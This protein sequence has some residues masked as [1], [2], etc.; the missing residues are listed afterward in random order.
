M[1]VI[2]SW[3]SEKAN[4]VRETSKF[5]NW[6]EP[7]AGAEFPAEANRYHLYVSLA[8][9]WANRT[10]ITLYMKGLQDIIGLSVTHPLFQRTRPEDPEDDHVGWAFV[11]PTETPWL[12]GPSG[13]GQ[14][15]SEGA[16]SDSVNNA[17]FV[18]DLVKKTIVS[19]ESADIIRMFN[20]SFDAI[21]PSKADLYPPKFRDDI[22]AIN[23]W[24]YDDINNGVYKCGLSTIQDEYDQ[25]VNKLFESLDRVEEILSKQ[26]ILVGDVF[27]EADVRLYTTLIRFDDV[28]FVHF[29][30]NKKMIAQYPNLLN[31]SDETDVC[32]AFID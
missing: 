24:I 13:L 29:K 21:A 6:I 15:S 3:V 26:R 22:N 28:Y 30:T 2:A 14:Y 10:L 25:A 23:E 4:F 31:V 19:N 27:T 12:P 1:L 8:C 5:R 18:R 11:D 7:D 32:V 16:T 17:K 20:S 9:P